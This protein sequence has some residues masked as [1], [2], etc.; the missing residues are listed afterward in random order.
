MGQQMQQIRHRDEGE[1][2]PGAVF[3]DEELDVLVEGNV[4]RHKHHRPAHTVAVV[5]QLDLARLLVRREPSLVRLCCGEWPV[6]AGQLKGRPHDL[7][8]GSYARP[9]EVNRRGAV[10]APHIEDRRRMPLVNVVQRSAL[11]HIAPS[12]D[13]PAIVHHIG[14]VRLGAH[15]QTLFGDDLCRQCGAVHSP[16]DV[17]RWAAVRVQRHIDREDGLLGAVEVL[18]LQLEDVPPLWV[19]VFPQVL[20]TVRISEGEMNLQAGRG[21]HCWMVQLSM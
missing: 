1:R 10:L 17:H 18:Y 3:A 9:L 4:E 20:Q 7:H 14:L 11:T 12:A 2:R 21:A 6:V 16:A 8:V 19:Y 5:D 13:G 15:H